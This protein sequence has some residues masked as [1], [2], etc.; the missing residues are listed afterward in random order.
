[1]LFCC[2]T[3][4]EIGSLS[5]LPF[6]SWWRSARWDYWRRRMRQGRYLQSCFQCGKVN[7]NDKL[8]QRFRETFG[9][10]AWLEVTGRG[11]EQ[12]PT[13]E[14]APL[15]GRPRGGRGLRVLP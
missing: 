10:Q 4:V 12:R 13:V 11:G 5:V 14:P 8:S 3:E 1:M 9:E 6:S 15:R 7:Q 2:N